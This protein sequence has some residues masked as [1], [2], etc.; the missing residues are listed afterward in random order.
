[1]H[2]Y[3]IY[4]VPVLILGIIALGA[5][6]PDWCQKRLVR[7]MIHEAIANNR[8]DSASRHEVRKILD[9]GEHREVVNWVRKNEELFPGELLA[10]TKKTIALRKRLTGTILLCVMVY[11]LVG[12]I[13]E[14]ELSG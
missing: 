6:Y 9:A 12:T 13:L 7:D 10:I 3:L 14:G 4:I 8:L 2:E 1:M 11:A 5:Y